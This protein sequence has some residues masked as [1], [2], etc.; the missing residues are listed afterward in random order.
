MPKESTSV[1]YYNQI[2]VERK[3]IVNEICL[4]KFF[5]YIY[6]ICGLGEKFKDLERKNY[7][8]KGKGVNTKTKASTGAKAVFSCIL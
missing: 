8:N 3:L 4:K 5:N 2:I 7:K 6:S 1:I